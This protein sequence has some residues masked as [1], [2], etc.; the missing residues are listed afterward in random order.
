[1][2]IAFITITICSIIYAV[3]SQEVNAGIIAGHHIP[4]LSE[5]EKEQFGDVNYIYFSVD[6]KTPAEFNLMLADY[7][8]KKYSD[9]KNT[10]EIYTV[11]IQ[12]K[13]HFRHFVIQVGDTP[14]RS[15]WLY[16]K[17]SF[18]SLVKIHLSQLKVWMIRHN[19]ISNTKYIYDEQK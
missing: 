5:E 4:G 13:D 15:K 9:I 8:D 19:L 2:L 17:G 7:I 10:D 11:T 1:M 6:F 14:I 16:E 3:T 18:P 12:I